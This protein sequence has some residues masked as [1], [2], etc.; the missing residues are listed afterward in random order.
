MPE[1]M[2]LATLLTV[3]IA[4]E[5]TDLPALYRVSATPPPSIEPTTP[6]ATPPIT[7]PIGPKTVPNVAPIVAPLSHRQR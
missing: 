6:P 2:E 3:S 7:V 1:P 4:E 5:T